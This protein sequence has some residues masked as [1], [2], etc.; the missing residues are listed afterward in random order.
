MMDYSVL[1]Q[2]QSIDDDSPEAL[3]I[4]TEG[5]LLCDP[6]L[7]ADVFNEPDDKIVKY[8]Y[9]FGWVAGSQGYGPILSFNEDIFSYAGEGVP[10][11]ANYVCSEVST[12]SLYVLVLPLSK[13]I[14][15]SIRETLSKSEGEFKII[16]PTIGKYETY[17]WEL[18]D[19]SGSPNRNFYLKYIGR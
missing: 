11:W 10:K 3:S 15:A 2:S 5:I 9:Q 14:P 16:K 12:D 7:L 4:G 19:G 6:N 17:I 8:I 1:V 13:S 18:D